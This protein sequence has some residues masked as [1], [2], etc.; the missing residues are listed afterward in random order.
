MIDLLELSAACAVNVEHVDVDRMET[1]DVD[2]AL[3]WRGPAAWGT[4]N[5]ELTSDRTFQF[6]DDGTR[7][8]IVPVAADYSYCGF[9]PSLIDL[10]AFKTDTPQRSWLLKDTAPV[11]NPMAIEKAAPSLGLDEILNVHEHPLAWLQANRDGV[12]VLDWS[13]N[14]RFWFSGVRRI[15]CDNPDIAKKLSQA[16]AEP[17]I[18][19]PEIRSR[20]V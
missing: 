13:A 15:W 17:S 19:L 18:R 1:L 16:L 20:E 4:G 12:V 11:L 8:C 6:N 2:R 10:L 7:A 14:L 3:Y 5:I 9:E